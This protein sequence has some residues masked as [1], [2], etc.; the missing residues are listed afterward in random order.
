MN[1]ARNYTVYI[2]MCDGD[3][4]TIHVEHTI[5]GTPE[6]MAQR[7]LNEMINSNS[8]I[9]IGTRIFNKKQISTIRVAVA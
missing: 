3:N 2:N 4:H 7:M 8:F 5:S 9:R 6:N 1:E